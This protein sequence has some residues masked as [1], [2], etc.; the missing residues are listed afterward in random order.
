MLECFFTTRVDFDSTQ[1]GLFEIL[2][3]T[4][5]GPDQ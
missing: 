4:G 1:D 3:H 2:G 5:G